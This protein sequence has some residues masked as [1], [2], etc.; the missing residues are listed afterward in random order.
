MG[1]GHVGARRGQWLSFGTGVADSSRVP[2]EY[3]KHR[4][5]SFEHHSYTHGLKTCMCNQ[6]FMKD[7]NINK[8]HKTFNY[9]EILYK[10]ETIITSVIAGMKL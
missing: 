1:L 3:S 8:Y 6:Y 2:S 5:T 9:I 10:T 4:A 7:E